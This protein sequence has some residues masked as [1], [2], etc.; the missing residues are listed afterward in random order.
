MENTRIAEQDERA[1]APLTDSEQEQAEHALRELACSERDPGALRVS[2]DQLARVRPFFELGWAVGVRTGHTGPAM[3]DVPVD[4]E[5]VDAAFAAVLSERV[6]DQLAV[7]VARTLVPWQSGPVLWQK[8]LYHGSLTQAHGRY[9]VQAIHAHAEPFG[10][11]PTLRY[12][13]CKMRGG[14]PETVVRNVR[15]QSLTPVREYRA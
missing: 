10:S 5:T 13:L 15:R 4:P 11:A 8:V 7:Q 3:A 9:W 14:V 1:G 6:A 12:D 2:P